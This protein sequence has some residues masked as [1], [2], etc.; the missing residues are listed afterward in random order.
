MES[1]HMEIKEVLFDVKK[2]LFNKLFLLGATLGVVTGILL[3]ISYM[4]GY[5]YGKKIALEDNLKISSE[6]Q[7]IIN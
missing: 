7:E 2:I 3:T 6:Q 4:G 5:Q 1:F